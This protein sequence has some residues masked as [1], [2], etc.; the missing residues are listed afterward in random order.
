[1]KITTEKVITRL[2]N[3]HDCFV[4]LGV[5]ILSCVL[6]FVGFVPKASASVYWENPTK[7][8]EQ[9]W[10][11]RLTNTRPW[12][13]DKTNSYATLDPL[14]QDV[15]RDTAS[16]LVIPQ[17]S[18][19]SSR[20]TDGLKQMAWALLTYNLNAIAANSFIPQGVGTPP[21]ETLVINT[22]FWVNLLRTPHGNERNH[23][24]NL[25]LPVLDIAQCPNLAGLNRINVVN[26]LNHT[27]SITN[28]LR[29]HCYANRFNSV[30]DAVIPLTGYVEITQSEYT[31]VNFGYAYSSSDGRIVFDYVNNRVFYTPAHYK[32]WKK[33]DFS[34]D[35]TGNYGC[36]PNGTC[37]NPFIELVQ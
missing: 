12:P 35:G 17:V 9:L 33:A 3:Y 1:M 6:V 15:S 34:P 11:A 16:G 23:L 31:G 14:V 27:A 30:G 29:W 5:I 7:A 32:Q 10:G 28:Q 18:I 25:V 26:T 4:K 20:V 24:P 2:K 22:A 19:N 13:I 37:A 21:A 8:I 36:T